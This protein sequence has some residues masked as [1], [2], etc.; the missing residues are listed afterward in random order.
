MNVILLL[1]LLFFIPF[2]CFLVFLAL[3]SCL[4]DRFRARHTSFGRSYAR[5]LGSGAGQ[6]GWEQIEMEDMLSDHSLDHD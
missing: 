6:A 1:T 4:G 2:L 5:G 3:S